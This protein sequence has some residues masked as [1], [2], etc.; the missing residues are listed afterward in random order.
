MKRKRQN[1]R[2]KRKEEQYQSIEIR[3]S[4]AV[5]P[6]RLFSLGRYM[7]QHAPEPEALIPLSFQ[8]SS[9][10]AAPWRRPSRS[11]LA[12]QH[13][14]PCDHRVSP[15]FAAEGTL[16]IL[17]NSLMSILWIVVRS[18]Y[19]ETGVG[20]FFAKQLY[21]WGDVLGR[22]DS[23]WTQTQRGIFHYFR[24]SECQVLGSSGACTS[25]H[26]FSQCHTVDP[27]LGD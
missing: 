27:T 1:K 15:S 16:S 20:A 22:H 14:A 4:R 17:I 26:Q 12:G 3:S 9:L 5:I 19:S 13:P 23:F 25:A 24:S 8:S 2:N 11:A 7:P 21:L 18:Q 6:R 10:L